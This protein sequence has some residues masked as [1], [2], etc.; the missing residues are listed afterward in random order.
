MEAGL[1]EHGCARKAESALV[2]ED[3]G[4]RRSTDADVERMRR[5]E[6][7][8]REKGKGKGSTGRGS[9]SGRRSG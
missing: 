5:G 3:E 2:E 1:Q 9:G 6:R 4:A 7:K 8:R